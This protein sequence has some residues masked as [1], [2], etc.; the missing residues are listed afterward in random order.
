MQPLS[1]IAFRILAD[2]GID[3]SI[4]DHVVVFQDWV[5]IRLNHRDHDTMSP[6]VNASRQ[7]GVAPALTEFDPVT[8]DAVGRLPL[9]MEGRI[10]L[11][12]RTNTFAQD[13]WPEQFATAFSEAMVLDATNTAPF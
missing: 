10:L 2:L 6:I 7:L 5:H 8:F 9:D 4:I 12:G 13:E 3:T 1:E 11:I